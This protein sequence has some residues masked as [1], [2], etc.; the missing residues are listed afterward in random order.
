MSALVL[1]L[2]CDGALLALSLAAIAAAR[3]RSGGVFVYAAACAIAA[4]LLVV[5]AYQLLGRLAPE[6]LTLPIGLPWIG[7]HFR[8]DALS[9][10]FV[11]V[12]NLGAAA[13]SLYAIGYGRHERDP[14]RVL[15]FYPAFLAGM[16]LVLV[17]DDAYTFLVSWEFMSL[18]SWAL[19]MAHH[20]ESGNRA[21]G[22]RLYRH[23]E[24]RRARAA[25]RVRAA[26]RPGG[27]YAFP[28]EAYTSRR[29]AP[30]PATP[31][32]A[33][34]VLALALVGAGSKAGLAPLHVWLPLAHPAA[35]SHVSALMSGV[36]DEGRGLRLHPH[37]VRS[38]R[39][40]GLVVERSRC[41]RSAVDRASSA[42]STR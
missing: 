26:R 11:I 35:P 9:A 42:S 40:A 32:L 10:F 15:P 25:A 6:E 29:C 21:R 33:G 19:V 41:W 31:G 1:L 28:A 36:D 2:G 14:A 24:L 4:V 8:L 18:A 12:V 13:A 30:T 23:G 3:S 7:A 38:A 20:R 34:L 27:A 22:L 37:R 5:G 39:A 16:N 17:A